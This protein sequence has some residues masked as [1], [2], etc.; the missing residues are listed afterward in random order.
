MLLRRRSL[1]A[2]VT[3]AATLPRVAIA[4]AVPELQTMRSTAK[5]WIWL[6]ED[7]ANA[8]GHFA[9][10]GVKVVS[11]A[12]SRGTNIASLAGCGVD[13][14]L[15][16]PGEAMNALGQGFA[17][18]SFVQTVARYASH[19]V[20]RKELLDA[21]GVTEASPDAARMAVLRGLRM[22]TTGPGAAPDNLLRWLAVRAGLNPNQDLRLVPIQGGGPGMVAGLQQKV[23][24]G[25]CLSSPSADIAVTRAGCA[26]LF[27]MAAN[28]PAE[29][30]PY[31]YIIAST[32]ERT[33]RD[34]REA[35]V[36]YVMGITMALRA[37]AADK[38][39]F[40]TFA[41]PFLEL[42]PAIAERAFA[43][44]SQIYFND[45]VPNPALFAKNV[46]FL[47]VSL[48]SQGEAPL[49]SSLSFEALFD[50]SVATEAARRLG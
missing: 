37:I 19:V 32:A 35:M 7:Y 16:D 4:Q 20:V 24:D 34:K 36:R 11:N 13:I 49:P 40:K 39:A 23:I 8:A 2:A 25:F 38:A 47:N 27:D 12:S 6:A 5:S 28:P 29:L 46:E 14:V 17:V 48:K 30:N 41:V 10:A 42:D 18:R 21:A 1:L 22:G 33:M 31:C 9:R 45:A 44:N 43:S 15:G 50:P 3:T 26:Y